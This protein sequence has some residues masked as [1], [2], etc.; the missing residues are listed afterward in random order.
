MNL[1]NWPLAAPLIL[2]LLA[3]WYIPKVVVVVIVSLLWAALLMS[4]A[5]EWIEKR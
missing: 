4:L 1:K 3:I 2:V 5:H